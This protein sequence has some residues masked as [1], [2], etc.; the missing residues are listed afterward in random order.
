MAS[1][2]GPEDLETEAGEPQEL[3]E[4]E[5]EVKELSAKIIQYRASL[6]DKLK[7]TFVSLLATQRPILPE[8]SEPGTSGDRNTDAGQGQVTSSIPADGDQETIE[9][10]RLLKDKISS[11]ASKMPIVLKRMRECISKIDKLDSQ[12]RTIHP[13]FK[14]KRTS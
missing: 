11:N 9:K 2:D 1:N 7:D 8:G 5:S 3:G 12:N 10:I 4:L 13:A 6:P 14:R